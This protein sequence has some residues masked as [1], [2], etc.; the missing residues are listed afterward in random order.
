MTRPRS[1]PSSCGS[2][3]GVRGAVA[4]GVAA[5]VTIGAAACGG[6]SNSAPAASSAAPAASTPAAAASGLQLPD[7]LFGLNKNTGPE[8]AQVTSAISRQFSALSSIARSHQA[9]VYGTAGTPDVVVFAAKWSSAF[10]HRA[11]SAA[12]DKDAAA[13]GTA[14][15]GST[16]ARSFPAGPHGGALRCGHTTRGGQNA[17]LCAWADKSTFG[18]VLYVSGSASTLSD[19]AAKTNQV[20]SAIGA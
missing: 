16:D 5:V 14:G 19:A 8:A 11:A 9:A 17:L 2:G 3:W 12:V 20:R 7:Q 18:L 10:A 15:A 4:L 6:S 1:S 13:G